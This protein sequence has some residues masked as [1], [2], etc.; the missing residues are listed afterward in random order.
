MIPGI[1]VPL[2]AGSSRAAAAAGA[3]TPGAQCV[4]TQ[5]TAG[6]FPI[7]GVLL[8]VEEKIPVFVTG[9]SL[10]DKGTPLVDAEG[11]PLWD[12]TF[13]GTGMST[14]LADRPADKVMRAVLLTAPD[15]LTG[16]RSELLQPSENPLAASKMRTRLENL[17]QMDAAVT[18][19]VAKLPSEVSR[20]KEVELA[21]AIN[22]AKAAQPS[23]LLASQSQMLEETESQQGGESS[24]R[25]R[26]PVSE[27]RQVRPKK[28]LSHLLDVDEQGLTPGAFSTKLETLVSQP[29]GALCANA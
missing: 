17:Q 25:A 6:Q 19:W 4:L 28:L 20:V 8:T 21:R 15:T 13:L 23:R 27:Q 3:V 12:V 10:D 29:C 14:N 26:S 22:E 1:I 9:Q 2:P 18:A 24:K 7:N 16:V 5:E 11:K